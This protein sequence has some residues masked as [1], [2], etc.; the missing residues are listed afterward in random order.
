[1]QN[2][3]LLYTTSEGNIN[4]QVQFEDGMFWLTQKRM[5]ELFGVEVNTINYHLKEIFKSGEL[6]ENSV[7]RKFRITAS[8][9]KKYLTSFYHLDAIISVG[10]RV[11]SYQATQF[12]IWATNTLREYI[13]K[14]FVLNDDM[15]K[16]GQSF[17]KDYF[18]ELLERIREIRASERRFYQKVTDIYIM[19]ADYDKN[20][21][22]TKDFFA[23]VQNKLHWAIT[24]KTAAEIIYTSTDAG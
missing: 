2:K 3:I 20:A 10:Y 11:N 15:L 4:V 18:D 22:V 13:T 12:R 6:H 23:S 5:A 14:G 9:G 17:G 8:D 1:M 7:I 21:P 24:G 16:N 19:A